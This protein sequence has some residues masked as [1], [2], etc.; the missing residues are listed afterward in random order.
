VFRLPEEGGCARDS[1]R[2]RWDSIFLAQS[3]QLPLTE[4][5]RSLRTN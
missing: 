2:P 1:S 3:R 5:S 4:F